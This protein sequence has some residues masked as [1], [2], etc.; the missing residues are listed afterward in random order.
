MRFDL[1]TLFPDFFRGP[2][3][4][5]VLQ[6]ARR[7]GRVEIALHDLRAFTHDRHRTV[8]DRPFGGGEGMVLKPEPLFASVESLGV[9]E[10]QQRD[11]GRQS[12][13]LLSAGGRRFDQAEARRLATLDQVVL[14]CG[15]YEGVDQRVADLLCDR[16]LSV[17][18][19]VLSG[20]ELGAA[21]IVDAVTRL[22][23]GVLGHADS[24]R[25]E[26][27]GEGDNAAES[28]APDGSLRTTHGSGGLLDYPQYTRPAEFRGAA[29]PAVL[30]SG[31]HTAI[32]R[33]RRR[34]A[35]AR[36]L[37]QRPD[38]LAAAELSPLDRNLLAELEND[39]ETTAVPTSKT[40][41]SDIH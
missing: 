4:F 40:A 21:V 19:Y 20:G 35:L 16:E 34:A 10:K 30:G 31:D 15:R 14:I 37:A 25:F 17:G 7:E 3:D 12:V 38:L 28:Y 29:I 13:I 41:D 5:G 39:G 32:R 22:L 1:I 26:S 18:D 9:A 24:S 6:R 33:W 36:T 11:T 8:D 2:F 23:P 27:F